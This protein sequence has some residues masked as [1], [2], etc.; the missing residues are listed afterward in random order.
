MNLLN[1]GLRPREI[2]AFGL[3]TR[4]YAPIGTLVGFSPDRDLIAPPGGGRKRIDKSLFGT[5]MRETTE[6][7]GG[8]LEFALA[9]DTPVMFY[10][11]RDNQRVVTPEMAPHVGYLKLHVYFRMLELTRNDPVEIEGKFLNPRFE[12][13]EFFNQKHVLRPSFCYAL[14]KFQGMG[15]WPRVNLPGRTPLQVNLPAMRKRMEEMH[16]HAKRIEALTRQ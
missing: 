10:L 13:V 12:P 8:G 3:I 4:P 11:D 5:Q 2:A 14:K 6:E 1:D 7:V 9:H 15:L 16:L